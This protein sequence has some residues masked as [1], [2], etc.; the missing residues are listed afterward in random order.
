MRLSA[1]RP[2]W[3]W[4][5]AL[6]HPGERPFRPGSP[7]ESIEIEYAD[8]ASWTSGSD[9]WVVYWFAMSMVAAL[10]FRPWLKVSI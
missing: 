4:S 8:R 10:C 1:K 2:G 7:V 9:W 6:L 3:S 5:D